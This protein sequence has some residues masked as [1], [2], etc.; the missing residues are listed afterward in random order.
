MS[1]DWNHMSRLCVC[2]TYRIGLNVNWCTEGC[3]NPKRTDNSKLKPR[4]SRFR[5]L[6]YLTSYRLLNQPPVLFGTTVTVCKPAMCSTFYSGGTRDGEVSEASQLDSLFLG[7]GQGG[8]CQRD[9]MEFDPYFFTVNAYLWTLCFHKMR[10]TAFV[11]T[12]THGPLSDRNPA[13]ILS[14][15]GC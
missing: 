3:Q 10:S 13:F 7:V 5:N 8:R 9:V 15:H 2:L 11:G 14:T 4:A 1:C 6:S 12:K